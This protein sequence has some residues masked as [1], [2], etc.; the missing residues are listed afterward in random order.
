MI[1]YG[2]VN[3]NLSGSASSRTTDQQ[4]FEAASLGDF[5][6]DAARVDRDCP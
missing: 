1:S 2:F 3:L 6:K 4:E 5:I